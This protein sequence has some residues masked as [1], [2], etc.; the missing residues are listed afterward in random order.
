ML[1][2]KDAPTLLTLPLCPQAQDHLPDPQ[3][4]HILFVSVVRA[5]H[6]HSGRRGACG[7]AG[8]P[9]GAAGQ[10]RLQTLLLHDRERQETPVSSGALGGSPCSLF[11]CLSV[12][13]SRVQGFKERLGDEGKEFQLLLAWDTH[14]VTCGARTMDDSLTFSGNL[15]WPQCDLEKVNCHPPSDLALDKAP[16]W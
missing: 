1:N 2:V 12:V 10:S 8:V 7:T 6:H 5:L 15:P 13:R 3:G 16:L 14:S 4:K 9:D 11:V